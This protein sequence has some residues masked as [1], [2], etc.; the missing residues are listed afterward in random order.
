[1]GSEFKKCKMVFSLHKLSH[2]I[3]LSMM[4]SQI[5]QKE[6]YENQLFA[7]LSLVLSVL[8]LLL[9]SQS[10]LQSA[11]NVNFYLFRKKYINLVFWLQHQLQLI[12]LFHTINIVPKDRINVYHHKVFLVQMD[13]VHVLHLYFGIQKLAHV[14]IEFVLKER[15]SYISDYFRCFINI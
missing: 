15:N 10:V 1:M 5:N 12:T 14:W 13:I 11:K 3:F 7:L 6:N 2:L 4:Y 9:E 8:L